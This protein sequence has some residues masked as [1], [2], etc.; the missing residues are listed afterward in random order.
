MTMDNFNGVSVDFHNSNGMNLDGYSPSPSSPYPFSTSHKDKF[1][2][3]EEM[4]DAFADLYSRYWK[5]GKRK[6]KAIFQFIT[7]DL[8][9]TYP[10]VTLTRVRNLDTEVSRYICI[11]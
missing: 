3:T 8:Q 1:L 5:E 9:Q 10:D 2:W 11:P 7:D 4:K 6:K